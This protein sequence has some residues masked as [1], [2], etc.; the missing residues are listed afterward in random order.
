MKWEKITSTLFNAHSVCSLCLDAQFYELHA[1]KQNKRENREIPSNFI[2]MLTLL[3]CSLNNRV[4]DLNITNHL[5]P[6]S[7]NVLWNIQGTPAFKQK[8]YL[9]IISV[10]CMC[11]YSICGLVQ[12]FRLSDFR[13]LSDSIGFISCYPSSRWPLKSWEGASPAKKTWKSIGQFF[14][15]SCHVQKKS[16]RFVSSQLRQSATMQWKPTE[17]FS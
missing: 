11:V 13:L 8:I 9:W 2:K 6:I 7:T 1:L 16:I 15:S 5:C 12:E 14:F 3:I 4:V 10:R 17:V